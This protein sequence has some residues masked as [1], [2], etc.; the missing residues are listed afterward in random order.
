VPDPDVQA[1]MALI[2]KLRDE[3]HLSWEKISDRADAFLAERQGRKPTPRWGRAGTG[4]SKS[5]CQ[6]I[7]ELAK[8]R[9]PSAEPTHRT[10]RQCRASLPIEDFQRNGRYR[11]RVCRWCR[12]VRTFRVAE[13]QRQRAFLEGLRQLSRLG[14]RGRFLSPAALSA[15]EAMARPFGGHFPTLERRCADILRT[16]PMNRAW[17]HLLNIAMAGKS[18]FPE[19]KTPLT[20]EY[21]DA[22]IKRVEQE[23]VDLAVAEMKASGDPEISAMDES[24]LRERVRNAVLQEQDGA[25]SRFKA[26]VGE[27]SDPPPASLQE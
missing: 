23:L 27:Y 14:Q 3:E 26:L 2:V 10:C 12:A 11:R 24:D 5:N 8:E 1:A 21:L 4:V 18:Q 25:E 17:T 6:R 13:E 22:R 15:V 20:L 16:K 9:K 7:Y 19:P